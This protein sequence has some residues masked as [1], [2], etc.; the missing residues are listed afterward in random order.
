M[1]AE[2]SLFDFIA[3]CAGVKVGESERKGVAERQLV[4]GGERTELMEKG[5]DLRGAEKVD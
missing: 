2:K 4:D 3:K 1:N 5:G